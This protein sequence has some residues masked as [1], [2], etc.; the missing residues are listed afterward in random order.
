M[1]K[2]RRMSRPDQRSRSAGGFIIAASLMVGT[3]VGLVVGEPSIGFLAGL[4]IGAITA[5]VLWLKARG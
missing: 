5:V 3:I 4:G 1:A 2:G